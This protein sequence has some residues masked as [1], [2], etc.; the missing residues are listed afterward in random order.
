MPSKD[1]L[2]DGVDNVIYAESLH[3]HEGRYSCELNLECP[4]DTKVFYKVDMKSSVSQDISNT[5]T[6]TSQNE[7][8]EE[9]SFVHQGCLVLLNP[10]VVKSSMKEVVKLEYKHKQRFLIHKISG[11][12]EIA[13]EFQ[14]FIP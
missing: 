5:V 14:S 4:S 2:A 8:D 3:Y 13:P 12:F 7:N 9:Y 6:V 10:C 1:P 11:I